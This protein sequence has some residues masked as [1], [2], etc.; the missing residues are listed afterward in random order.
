MC[1]WIYQTNE[2][3]KG[4]MMINTTGLKDEDKVIVTFDNDNSVECLFRGG[5]FVNNEE[6]GH[7]YEVY[8]SSVA[9]FRVD[10]KEGCYNK[11]RGVRRNEQ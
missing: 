6:S 5:V 3:D 11:S 2:M 4:G 7:K 1:P 8:G 10:W 9:A